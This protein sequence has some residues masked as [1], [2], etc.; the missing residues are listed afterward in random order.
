[1]RALGDRRREG[2]A[3]ANQAAAHDGAGEVEPAVA[4]YLQAIDCLGGAG[5]TETRAA[6]Y[7]KLSALQ[8]K[9]GQQLQA[10]A[11]MRSGLNLSSELTPK[12]K[13]LKELLDKAMKMTGL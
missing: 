10:L 1:F 5:E 2:E 7:K 9:L 11:S 6:C 3:L 4:L 13:A 8:I 12:E